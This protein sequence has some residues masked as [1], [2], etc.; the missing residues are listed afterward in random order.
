MFGKNR[1]GIQRLRTYLKAVN[2]AGER[3]RCR[4]SRGA[5]RSA[6]ARRFIATIHSG[7]TRL[8]VR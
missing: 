4:A 1:N 8:H 7:W 3:R 5:H 2:G 6:A